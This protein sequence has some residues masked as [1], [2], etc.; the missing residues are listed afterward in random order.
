M[1]VEFI[2]YLKS[3]MSFIRVWIHYV[4]ATK[5][6][7]PV[8][9]KD[10]RSAIHDHIRQNAKAKNIH[11]DRINGHVEHVHCLISLGS[12]QTIDKIAQLLKGESSNW[13]NHKS[14]LKAQRLDWQDEYFAVSISESGVDAVRAYIDNQEEHHKKKT[15]AGEYNELMSKYGFIK[16]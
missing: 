1:Q 14:G 9:T 7:T 5:N 2:Y 3:S 13:L 12:Q 16:D 15:F 6:R 8:L 11:L 10:I 4:W